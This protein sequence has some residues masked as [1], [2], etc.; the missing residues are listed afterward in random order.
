MGTKTMADKWR[1]LRPT[2]YRNLDH[3]FRLLAAVD[4]DCIFRDID[5]EVN[6]VFSDGSRYQMTRQHD[7]EERN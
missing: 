1:E 6:I 3:Y 5:G 4:A 7:G 2:T